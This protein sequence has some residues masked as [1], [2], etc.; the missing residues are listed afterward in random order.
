MV[1]I[2]IDTQR[3]SAHE[4]RRV[5]ALLQQAIGHIPQQG[6]AMQPVTNPVALSAQPGDMFASQSMVQPTVQPS[7]PAGGFTDMFAPKEEPTQSMQTSSQSSSPTNPFSM[8]DDAHSTSISQD[9]SSNQSVHQSLS[10][11]SQ[12]AVHGNDLFGMFS[13]DLPSSSPSTHDSLS[14]TTK[15]AQDL[16]REVSEEEYATSTNDFIQPLNDSVDTKKDDDQDF[17]KLATY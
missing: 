15:S 13:S 6:V 11:P 3:D 5:I 7:K 14:G 9:Q 12:T 2:T 16:L 1:Q 4:I 10:Q 8:F 17:F